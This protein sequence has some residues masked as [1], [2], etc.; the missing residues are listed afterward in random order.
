MW[1]AALEVG[2]R[3]PSASSL[4]CQLLAWQGVPPSFSLLAASSS[5]HAPASFCRSGVRGLGWLLLLQQFCGTR[6]RPPLYSRPFLKPVWQVYP[7]SCSAPTPSTGCVRMVGGGGVSQCWCGR[8]VPTYCCS[9]QVV[10]SDCQRP[11]CLTPL[12]PP[13]PT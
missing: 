8:G 9:R 5:W 12:S 13:V 11:P 10:P 1:A 7:P 6:G 4:P 2:A 3:I